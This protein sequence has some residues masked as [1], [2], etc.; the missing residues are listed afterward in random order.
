[1]TNLKHR[2][3]R[4]YIDK[5]SLVIPQSLRPKALSILRWIVVGCIIRLLLMPI[6]AHPDFTTTLWISVTLVKRHQLIFSNDPPAVFFL[7]SGF[8]YFMMPLFS[9]TFVNF[10]TTRTAFTPPTLLQSFSLLQPGIN[11][12]LLVGKI[13]FLL[14]DI[15]SAFLMLHLFTDE[16]KGF[17]AFRIWILNPVSIFVSYIF[18]QFDIFA[19]FFIIL[20]LYFLKKNRFEWSMLSLGFAG[21][22]KIVG[23][24]LIP[25]VAI[26]FLKVRKEKRLTTKI[27]GLSRILVLG[28]LPFVLIPITFLRVPQYYESVNAAVPR[29]DM[30]NGFFGRTFYTRGSVGQPF[31]SGLFF[32]LFDLSIS[33]GTRSLVPIFGL[34]PL[35]YMLVLLG[36]TYERQLLFEKVCSYFTVFLLAYYAFSLFHPQWFLWVQPFLIILAVEN[37][38][39]FGKLY[40]LLMP[41]YFLYTWQWDADLTTKL[42]TPIIPQALFWPGPITLMN[43]VGLPAYQILNLFRTIFSAVCIFMAYFIIKPP[44]GAKAQKRYKSS[45]G[46][47]NV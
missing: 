15:M 13:P 9:S 2:S 12:V 39:V 22:F 6:F 35:V 1:M 17:T 29:G 33:F 41:L 19:V 20:A 36:A 28:L 21:I 34:I 8:Y 3:I 47:A 37:R 18:G 42:V 14:F 30:F 31:Y 7:L 43:S 4:G 45:V 24:V 5:I 38:K 32:F 10:V 23:F 46:D 11:T 44:L 25:L 16:T 40:V 27:V 26:R